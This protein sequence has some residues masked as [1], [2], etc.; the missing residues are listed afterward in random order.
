MSGLQE[1]KQLIKDALEIHLNQASFHLSRNANPQFDS[2][3]GATSYRGNYS[4]VP[5]LAS[6]T[7]Q[8]RE[9]LGMETCLAIVKRHYFRQKEKNEKIVKECKELLEKLDKEIGEFQQLK[10]ENQNLK[11]AKDSIRRLLG[12]HEQI[13]QRLNLEKA[14][15]VK[16]KGE[17]ETKLK[18]EVSSKSKVETE[19][20]NQISTLTTQ[21]TAKTTDYDQFLNMEGDS[22]SAKH[23]VEELESS[24]S[25]LEKGRQELEQ[26]LSKVKKKLTE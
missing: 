26:Q 4:E 5:E 16:Q 18:N 15:L 11:Q 6:L 1:Y 3:G 10:T 8:E 14:D 19:L 23:K 2:E 22:V 13:S 24:V 12:G 9:N 20:K 21:L 17:L 25:S 7:D